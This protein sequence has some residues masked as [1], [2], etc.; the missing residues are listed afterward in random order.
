METSFCGSDVPRRMVF[1][2]HRVIIFKLHRVINIQRRKRNIFPV[3][4]DKQPVEKMCISFQIYGG[5]GV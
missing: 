4:P 1:P 3:L 2:I 5:E